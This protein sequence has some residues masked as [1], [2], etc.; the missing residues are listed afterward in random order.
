[1]LQL[2]CLLAQRITFMIFNQDVTGLGLSQD[3]V[4]HN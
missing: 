1:M 3:T 2:L 4:F